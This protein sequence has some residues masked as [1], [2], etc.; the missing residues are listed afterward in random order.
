LQQI[1]KTYCASCCGNFKHIN[2]VIKT[3]E[4]EKE[5][6][7]FCSVVCMEYYVA[8]FKDE[9]KCTKDGAVNPK[10]KVKPKNKGSY[11]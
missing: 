8:E 4:G 5:L 9:F 10:F 3:K 11:N 6:F 2:S 7:Y 1:R